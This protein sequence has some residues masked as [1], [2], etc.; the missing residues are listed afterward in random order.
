MLFIGTSRTPWD[1]EQKLLFQ[2]YQKVIQIPRAD[3][4][5]ISLMWKT[6]LHRAG[7]LS[8]RLEV[9]C[10]S[11]ISDSYTIGMYLF[12]YQS[13]SKKEQLLLISEGALKKTVAVLSSFCTSKQ[14]R[15]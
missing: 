11:R 10:L 15:L 4:G 5:S 3:Y 2:C 13:Q 9:S 6:K 7:A 1:A 12:H 14:P 8:P